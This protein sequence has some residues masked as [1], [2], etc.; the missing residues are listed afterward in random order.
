MA[1][2]DEM[3]A[4]VD[5]DRAD[6]ENVDEKYQPRPHSRAEYIGFKMRLAGKFAEILTKELRQRQGRV[7]N[8]NCANYSVLFRN[9]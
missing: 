6:F 3:Y 5:V 7:I 1:P 9:N 4:D 8:E 2:R